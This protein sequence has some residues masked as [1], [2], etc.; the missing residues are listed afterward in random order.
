MSGI[1]I[2]VKDAQRVLS[3]TE[4]PIGRF[5]DEVIKS[6]GRPFSG[7]GS[8]I[9]FGDEDEYGFN[10][11]LGRFFEKLSICWKF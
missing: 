3:E 10:S 8:V 7:N 1:N 2:T 5:V 11:F 6:R 9:L 4:I